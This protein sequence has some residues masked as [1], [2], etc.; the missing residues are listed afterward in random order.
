[1]GSRFDAVAG[2]DDIFNRK[3]ASQLNVP[4]A[5]ID[6]TLFPDG[7]ARPRLLDPVNGK[8]LFVRRLESFPH[9]H[10]N[11][12]FVETIFTIRMLHDNNARKVHT[13]L[14][15]LPYSKQ[16][17]VFQPGE[18]W[19]LRYALEAVKNAGCRKV[20]TVACHACRDE[21]ELKMVRR[22]KVRNYLPFG[23]ISSFLNKTGWTGSAIVAPDEKA[24]LWAD[25]V[26]KETQGKLT[27]FVKERD[28]ET[29]EISMEAGKVREG[30]AV[31]VDD[32]INAGST[33]LKA[34]AA[35]KKSGVSDIAAAC[36]HFIGASNAAQRIEEAG[37]EIITTNTIENRLSKIDLTKPLA[38]WL[39]HA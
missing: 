18:A 32:M 31:I 15:Y 14:P 34:I 23:H 37:A 33:V 8:V 30:H 4:F 25:Q 11:K 35:L 36:T 12:T 22:I 6:Y 39:S 5:R 13:L 26:A 21:K 7:E 17:K 9:F 28:R 2:E 1:M 16:D 24:G 29:G 27:V 20:Y 3:L 19:S 10:P 38:E